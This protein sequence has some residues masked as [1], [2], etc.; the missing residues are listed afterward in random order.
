MIRIANGP[1]LDDESRAMLASGRANASVALFI[2][3]IVEMRGLEE[4]A[5]EVFAG[6]VLETE[7]PAEMRADALARVLATID[8]GLGVGRGAETSVA[9]AYPELI[10]LPA[11]LTEKIR[12]AEAR[13]G[14]TSIGY[15]VRQLKLGEAGGV[16]AEILRSPPGVATPKHTHRGREYTLCLVGQFSDAT[17]NYGPGDVAYADPT[18]THQPTADREGGPVFVLAITDAGLQL[19]GVMGVLQ[20]LIGK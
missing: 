8:S 5:G 2:D 16:N 11:V 1:Y 18:V 7:A 20:R 9:S 13:K 4:R 15:G 10:R 19:T 12:D 3:T 17:G 6:V 14:W